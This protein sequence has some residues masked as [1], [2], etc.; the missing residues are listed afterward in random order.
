MSKLSKAVGAQYPLVATFEFTVADTM[1]NTSGVEVGFDDATG[2]VFDIASVPFSS[3]LIGGDIV[4]KVASN[5]AGTATISLGDAGS[6]TRY[7][8]AVNMKVAARTA[9]TLTGFATTSAGIR[10]T[11]ANATGGATLGTVKVS[12]EFLVDGRQNENLKTV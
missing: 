3:Q 6:A 4:V 11:L 7:A 5:D 2:T 12:M 9:L 10:M 1:V 8:S